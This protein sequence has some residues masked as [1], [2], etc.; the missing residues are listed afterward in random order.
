M[1]SPVQLRDHILQQALAAKAIAD[2]EPSHVTFT[3]GRLQYKVV[4]TSERLA[5]FIAMVEK[6]PGFN[7]PKAKRRGKAPKPRRIDPAVFRKRYQD[8]DEVDFNE[9]P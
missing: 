4:N 2:G 3:S 5:Q 9:I 8:D 7:P 6:C 1:T